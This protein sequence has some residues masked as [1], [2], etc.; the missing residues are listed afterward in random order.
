M[1]GS[2]IAGLGHRRRARAGADPREVRDLRD[3]AGVRARERQ[4]LEVAKQPR[5]VLGADRRHL[6]C[7]PGGQ[8]IELTSKP[9]SVSRFL[10]W[11]KFRPR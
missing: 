11:E 6:Q 1:I 7:Y 10:R 3:G 9:R 4:E 8:K 5:R 2:A